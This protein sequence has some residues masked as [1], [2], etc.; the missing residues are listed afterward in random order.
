MTIR[1]HF[2]SIRTVLTVRYT[3]VFTAAFTVMAVTAYIY[4]E[5][6][7]V[8]V[9]ENDLAAEA[10]WVTQMMAVDGEDG[11]NLLN[12]VSDEFQSRIR[13]HFVAVSRNYVV[14]ISTQNKE[15]LF[16]LEDRLY[17]GILDCPA[18][19]DTTRFSVAT[20]SSSE[21]F[22]VAG[23][24]AGPYFVHVAATERNMRRVL[25]GILQVFGWFFA[26]ILLA[27]AVV[28]WFLARLALR[29]IGE[30]ASRTASITASNL[31][32]RIP[33]RPV[34]D[35]LGQLTDSI[36]YALDRLDQS[37]EQM[38]QFSQNAAHELKTP[39]TI[40][41]GES[42]LAL[43]RAMS[44]KEQRQLINT[45]LEETGRMAR[46]VDDLLML[47]KADAGQIVIEHSEVNLREIVE[48]VFDDATT[49]GNPKSISVQLV[50]NEPALVLGDP[51]RL[52]QLLRIL[53]MNAIQYTGPGG[54][55][56]LKSFA[57]KGL[58]RVDVEDTGKGIPG[59]HLARIFDRFYRVDEARTRDHG[60][61]GLGLAIAQWIVS[62]HGG[63]IEVRSTPGEGSR[64]TVR[65][66]SSAA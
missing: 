60:G 59:E 58:C 20:I 50:D 28:G 24:R 15:V 7:L 33:R 40:L 3:L 31:S 6:V 54:S 49:L 12:N 1:E 4:L 47:A 8:G 18:G 30:I 39:L 62:A 35:E 66:P 46:I 14:T 61:S 17:P 38:R 41:R 21:R 19:S 27:A 51:G 56:R 57:E 64:F 43:T 36:N 25:E 48:E 11:G 53:V 29:P 34:P 65:I 10:D 26:L 13:K 63:T 2:R 55:I 44:T 52:R 32:E 22:R 37:F 16:A 42:E 45:Y 23:V 9:L 5:H